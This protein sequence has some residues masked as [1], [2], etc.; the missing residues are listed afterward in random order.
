MFET[1][2]DLNKHYFLNYDN[3]NLTTFEKYIFNTKDIKLNL[4]NYDLTKSDIVNTFALYYQIKMIENSNNQ[5]FEQ[6]YLAMLFKL[7]K[8]KDDRGLVRLGRY[9]LLKN[10]FNKASFYFKQSNSSAAKFNLYFIT[11]NVDYLINILKENKDYFVIYKIALHYF[12][13]NDKTT[14]FQYFEYGIYKGCK[15]SLYQL[16]FYFQNTQMLYIYLLKLPFTNS[17]IQ[18]K[19]RELNPRI[20]ECDINY[21]RDKKIIHVF[22]DS[23]KEYFIGGSSITLIDLYG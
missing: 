5:N 21:L 13:I 8:L 12:E 1:I 15:K 16:E 19:I 23:S 3:R 4:H 17:L 7:C 20:I 2:Q 11:K 9:Y 22:D 18:N 6:L 14:S 10:N